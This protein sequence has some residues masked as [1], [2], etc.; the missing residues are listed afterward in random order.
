MKVYNIV[1]VQRQY[2]EKYYLHN[3]QNSKAVNPY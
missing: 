3:S 1:I 2:C